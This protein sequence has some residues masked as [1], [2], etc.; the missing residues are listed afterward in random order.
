MPRF[1][2][3][4]EQLADKYGNG[5]RREFD[6]THPIKTLHHIAAKTANFAKWQ[7]ER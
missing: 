3:N 1:D 6:R 4:D 7:M 2:A 5:K